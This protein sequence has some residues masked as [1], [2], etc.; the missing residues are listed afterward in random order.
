[1]NIQKNLMRCG[2]LL[3]AVLALAPSALAADAE[4]AS[5]P[6][7]PQAVTPAAVSANTSKI[8]TILFF[9]IVPSQSCL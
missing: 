8:Q 7:V 5:V 1:M 3:A 9:I 6:A 2:A 4:T